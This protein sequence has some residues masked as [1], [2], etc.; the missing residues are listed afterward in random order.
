MKIIE[1]LFSKNILHRDDKIRNYEQLERMK[2]LQK[3]NCFFVLLYRGQ[4]VFNGTTQ[5]Y[6]FSNQAYYQQYSTPKDEIIYLGTFQNQHY[7]VT[8][9]D[10][11][12]HTNQLDDLKMI[13][14]NINID[15]EHLSIMAQ[16]LG[17]ANWNQTHKFCGQCGSLNQKQHFGWKKYCTKCKKEHF[18]RLDPAVIMLLTNDKNEV[19]LGSGVRFP[20]NRYS[21]L[22]GFM[23]PGESI[24]LAAIREVY[25]ESGIRA[26]FKSYLKSQPWPFPMGLMIGVHLTTHQQN[27]KLDTNEIRTGR[28][29]TKSE[30]SNY[31]KEEAT[32]FSLPS[33]YGIARNILHA[34]SIK[35]T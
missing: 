19:F 16:A 34:W 11:L 13:T 28:W 8:I 23:E 3:S 1:P 31:F 22:A 33:T 21:L 14:E 17:I 29:F 27:F 7:F 6:I 2:L 24:E 25:E 30:I 4:F 26:T 20:E 9:L 18:P 35:S 5:D 10:F 15:N 32:D 12:V